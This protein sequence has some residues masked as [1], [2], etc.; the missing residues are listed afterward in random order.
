MTKIIYSNLEDI[1]ADCP[2]EL[3]YL[4]KKTK[5]GKRKR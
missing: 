2:K 5:N 3:E 1:K 4:F